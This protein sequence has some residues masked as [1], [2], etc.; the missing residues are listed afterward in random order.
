MF[1]KEKYFKGMQLRR[2]SSKT[3]NKAVNKNAILGVCVVS[4]SLIFKIH[5]S[6]LKLNQHLHLSQ[7]F[8]Y[9]FDIFFMPPI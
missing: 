8:T 9:N 1:L 4:V 5:D 7:F 3:N 2:G 6:S